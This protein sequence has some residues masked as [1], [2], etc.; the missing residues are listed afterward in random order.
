MIFLTSQM[1]V[2]SL[3]E[4]LY[5]SFDWALTV[6]RGQRGNFTFFMPV[7]GLPL[8]LL[9]PRL[10]PRS[11]ARKLY[12]WY[13]GG[14]TVYQFIAPPPPPLLHPICAPELFT[15]PGPLSL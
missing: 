5:A 2:T 7:S 13:T 3:V 9:A 1:L 14:F 10:S 12:K 4:S 11:F 6:A 15:A 8:P